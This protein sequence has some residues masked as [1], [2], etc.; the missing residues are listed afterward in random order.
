MAAYPPYASAQDCIEALVKATVNQSILSISDLSIAWSVS[1]TSYDEMKRN[2]GTSAVIYGV[3]LGA[4]YGEFRKNIQTMQQA[5]QLHNFELYSGA[6]A[7]TKLDGNSLEAYRSCL[8]AHNK[9]LAVLVERIGSPQSPSYTIWVTYIPPANQASGLR[10]RVLNPRNLATESQKNIEKEIANQEFYSTVDRQFTIIPSDFKS[11]AS[12]EIAVGGQSKVLG[13]PPILTPQLKTERVI[14]TKPIGTCA[15][16]S[17]M[18]A[19]PVHRE[20]EGCFSPTRPNAMFVQ[21]TG[22]FMEDRHV[23][24]ADWK[25]TFS[26][27]DTICV[28]VFADNTSGS[29]TSEIAGRITATQAYTE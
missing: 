9:G 29:T 12:L 7:S 19:K 5:F 16:Y 11:G 17:C 13:L 21:G 28:K 3:P 18:P 14:D 24:V 27:P 2:M 10:G 22:H 26:S 8:S 4:D 1:S 20:A 6:Y 25:V 15:G 23:L